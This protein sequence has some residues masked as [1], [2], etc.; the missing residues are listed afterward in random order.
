MDREK[1]LDNLYDLTLTEV[2]KQM[3]SGEVDDK[4]LT[5]AMRF[6]KDNKQVSE[7]K[8]ETDTHTKIKDLMNE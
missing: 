4:L 2:I 7:G 1:L 6:L 3:E 8:T 5:V